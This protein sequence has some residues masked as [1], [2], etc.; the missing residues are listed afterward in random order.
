MTLHFST[1]RH[2]AGLCG[3]ALTLMLTASVSATANE[4][5]PTQAQAQYEIRFMTD[6]I[7][8][9]W[10]AVHM[11]MMCLEKAVHPELLEMCAQ[12]RD[13]Q[14]QEIATMQGWL[15]EWYGVS[16]A[17]E[18]TNGAMQRMH[19]MHHMTAEEFEIAFMKSMIRH[20]WTA[21]V[22]ATGCLDRAYHSDLIAICQE[23]V[24]A[25]VSEI[26]T[27]R[28]WLCEWYGVCSYGPKG[29]VASTH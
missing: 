11:A 7:D 10:M 12:I 24:I 22:R 23:I 2:H 21:V 29:N 28:T 16:Y 20:H 26:E 6:M 14:Q 9:H 18:M 3:A 5:A 15:Q 1:L 19:R 17:P 4:P 8:H 13:T 27:M 25:Q